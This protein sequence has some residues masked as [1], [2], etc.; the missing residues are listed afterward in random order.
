MEKTVR[1]GERFS[2][3][4]AKREEKKRLHQKL[5][6]KFEAKKLFGLISIAY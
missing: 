2:G 3:E 1:K 6:V 5:K 4:E